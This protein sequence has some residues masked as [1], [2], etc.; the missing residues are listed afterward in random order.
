MGTLL[1]QKD[2]TF[3]G[4]EQRSSIFRK[5]KRKYSLTF[6]VLADSVDEKW[7]EVLNTPGLPRPLEDFQGDGCR[8]KNRSPKEAKTVMQ[9]GVLTI[10][11]TVQCDFDSEV[12]F[13]DVG[14]D[15]EILTDPLEW[16]TTLSIH[17]HEEKRDLLTA[18]N[19]AGTPIENPNGERIHVEVTE[20][21]PLIEFSRYEAYPDTPEGVVSF[22]GKMASYANTLNSEEFLGF[23]KYSCLMY[24][25]TATREEINGGRY[26]RVTYRILVKNYTQEEKEASGQEN[27]SPFD[28]RPL[29]EGYLV[30]DRDT[31]EIRS[32]SEIYGQNIKVNL[33]ADGYELADGNEPHFLYFETHDASDFNGLNLVPDDWRS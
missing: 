10:L 31:G 32:T 28:V 1:G 14:K 4:N 24:A 17:E 23:P 22:L 7:T 29:C 15:Q 6:D 33:D 20:S 12:V 13:R 2:G 21:Y 26:F 18:W 25:P 30:R 5:R 11:W 19:D 3:S 27:Y 16:P 9:D 8:C